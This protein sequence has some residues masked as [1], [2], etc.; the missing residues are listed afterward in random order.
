MG[1]LL[2]LSKELRDQ[3]KSVCAKNGKTMKEV[4]IELIVSYIKNN[5]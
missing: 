4:L 3:F 5:K 2:E 1:Y